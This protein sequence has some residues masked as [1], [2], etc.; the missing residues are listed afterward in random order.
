[1]HCTTR[2]EEYFGP[3][4][5]EPRPK[6]ER[7]PGS[8]H[9][10]RDDARMTPSPDQRGREQSMSAKWWGMTTASAAPAKNRAD[11]ETHPTPSPDYL[12]QA[13]VGRAHRKPQP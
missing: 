4:V 11:V 6:A 5:L 7:F 3:P 2:A 9:Q 8:P 10:T 13:R 1:M 12:P